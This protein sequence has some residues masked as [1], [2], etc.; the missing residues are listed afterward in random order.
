[1]Y[2][3][4]FAL[5]FIIQFLL[6]YLIIDT[7]YKYTKLPKLKKK[8][9]RFRYYNGLFYYIFDLIPKRIAEFIQYKQSD[10]F[11]ESGLILYCGAQGEGKSYAM[12]HEVTKLYCQYP[13]VKI[14]SNIWFAISD[15]KLIDYQPLLEEK[16]GESGIIFM[17]DEISMWWNSRFRGLDPSVLSELVTN[18]KNH[19]VL[20]GTCQNISMCDKQVRLQAS[21]FRNVH[22]FLGAFVL[23]TCWKPE[24]EMSTGDLKDKHFLGFKFYI[25]DDVIR[26]S[27]DTYEMIN[28]L[29]QYG[30]Q[31]EKPV[32]INVRGVENEKKSIFK[33]KT[34]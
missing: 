26:Y 31:Y 27:Y 9:Q 8:K 7:F 32:E 5:R 25:Q 10:E 21:E 29:N 13:D 18:R 4:L 23:C 20:F 33:K 15:K 2:Y 30:S 6:L 14:L 16:N 34:A 12:C 22:C 28:L 24:F 17:L 3:I 1:M 19:R 11:S